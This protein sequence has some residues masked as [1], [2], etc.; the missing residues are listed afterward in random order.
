MMMTT[1]SG[2]YNIIAKS[3]K[4]TVGRNLNFL[5][6]LMTIDDGLFGLSRHKTQ[7]YSHSYVIDDNT[8]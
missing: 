4:P 1:S 8:S 7:K 6:A 2:V 5:R 3:C